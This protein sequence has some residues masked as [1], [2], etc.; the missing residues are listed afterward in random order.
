MIKIFIIIFL[1]I[2]KL[3]KENNKN[4]NSSFSI[5]L[6]PKESQFYRLPF[7]AEAIGNDFL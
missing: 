1:V 6:Q 3:M 7:V 2:A 5:L 4:Q